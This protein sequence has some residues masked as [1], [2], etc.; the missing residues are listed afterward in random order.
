MPSPFP[1]MNPFL[2][3]PDDWHTFHLQM[4][5]AMSDRLSAQVRPTILYTWRPTSTASA[6]WRFS[7]GGTANFL[8]RH[9]GGELVAEGQGFASG[10]LTSPPCGRGPTLRELGRSQR[11]Q[12]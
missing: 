12:F 2:E 11:S 9:G 3:H 8:E 5:A 4:I 1:G 6:T 7:T 10:G